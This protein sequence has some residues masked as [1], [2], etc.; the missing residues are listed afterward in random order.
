[1][2]QMVPNPSG[3]DYIYFDGAVFGENDSP[4]EIEDAIVR[5]VLEMAAQYGFS[6]VKHD[7]YLFLSVSKG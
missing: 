4:R 5:R 7:V 6:V 1:M 2:G 3:A